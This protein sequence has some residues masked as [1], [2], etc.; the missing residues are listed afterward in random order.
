M[1]SGSL[2]LNAPF[3]VVHLRFTTPPV[4][5]VLFGCVRRMP[6]FPPLAYEISG[7]LLIVIHRGRYGEVWRASL[8]DLEVAVKMFGP[9]QKQY[10]MNERDIYMLP[11]MEHDALP[12]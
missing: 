1:F 7:T 5:F 2:A 6:E 8:G 11:L 10:Y 12:R 3:A 9:H 4:D